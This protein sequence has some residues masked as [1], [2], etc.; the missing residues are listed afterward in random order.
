MDVDLVDE[1]EVE[2]LRPDVGGEDPQLLALGSLETDTHG[3]LDGTAEQGDV[4]GGLGGL[5]VL[6]MVGEDEDRSVPG[7]AERS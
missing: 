5:G 7:P 1:P 4:V 2:Q 3:V 6:G